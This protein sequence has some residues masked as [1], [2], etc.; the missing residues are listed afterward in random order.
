LLIDLSTGRVKER[1]YRAASNPPILHRKETFLSQDHHWRQEFEKL[2]QEEEIEGLYDSGETIGFRKGWEA[3]LSSRGLSYD[4][5]RLIRVRPRF[6]YSSDTE[7]QILRHKTA[8]A[9][10]A[11]SRPVQKLIQYGLLGKET[12]FLDYGCGQGDDVRHL[13]ELGF[14]VFSWDPV[15]NPNGPR[16]EVEVVNL[17]F[18]LNVIEDPVERS[19]VLRDAYQLSRKLLVVSAQIA[20]SS[21]SMS[22]VP[23]KD[24]YLTR[25]RTFQKY[26]EQGELGEYIEDVLEVST[27]PVGL[28]IFFVFR[29][30]ADRQIFLANRYRRS[31]QPLEFIKLSR[32][33]GGR[34]AK[35]RRA[36]VYEENRDLLDSFWSKMLQLGRLPLESEYDRYEDIRKIVGSGKKAQRLFLRK[37]GDEPLLK[38]SEKIRN[39]LQ[40]YL[41]LSSFRKPPPFRDLP[42][43]LQVDIKTF[44]GG[45]AQGIKAS[46]A[47]LFSA[48]NPD[49]VAKVCDQTMV[50]YLDQ[51]AL[52]FHKS[53]L[54]E[55]HPIL[56]VYVG[57][58]EMLYGDLEGVDIIKIHKRSGKLSLLKYDNYEGKPL[59]ELQERVKIDLRRLRIEVF[60]HRSPMQQLLFF[61]ERYVGKDHPHR[62]KWM[63]FTEWLQS[64]DLDL[65]GYG[66]SKEELVLFLQNKGLLEKLEQNEW[67][68]SVGNPETLR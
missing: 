40:V 41:A 36:D 14:T 20:T 43:D 13:K 34:R 61:K 9:R 17:G 30:S 15:F 49:V 22:G 57:C 58:G 67:I 12:P 37:F 56:R 63:K 42:V 11:L 3:L 66:P 54:N 48:G 5:H 29:H 2:T 4:S 51:K 26:F 7:A 21:E 24:G 59:P 25:R 46:K 16:E 32:I 62:D 60:D 31:L 64:L 65:G 52:L 33:I 38:A 18:V 23:Y 68:T 28:G 10:Y 44:L 47:L 1:D 27:V 45:Y 53:L 35:A 6:D 55:L 50:G 19:K 8:I 39:D